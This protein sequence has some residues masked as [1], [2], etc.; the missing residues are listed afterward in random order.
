MHCFFF[1]KRNLILFLFCAVL[2]CVRK[3]TCKIHFYNRL[4][5]FKQ[6]ATFK[7]EGHYKTFKELQ[8]A[9]NINK[10]K[11]GQMDGQKR[12]NTMEVTPQT[13]WGNMTDGAG[14][15]LSSLLQLAFV[16]SKLLLKTDLLKRGQTEIK[17]QTE[18]QSHT[19]NPNKQHAVLK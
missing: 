3:L 11:T 5:T 12:R 2:F 13:N 9:L 14:Q 1:W 15:Y 6:R 8:H 18:R 17:R 10:K 7:S 4:L 16:I 19:G